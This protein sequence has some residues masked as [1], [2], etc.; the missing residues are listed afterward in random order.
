AN[1]SGDGW[2]LNRGFTVVTLGWQWDAYGDD[3]LRLFAPVAKQNSKTITGLLRGDY[4]PWKVMPDIPLGHFYARDAIGGS[5]Y[6]VA[7]RDDPR[8]VLTVRESREAPRTT[9][10]NSQWQ[11]A[12]TVDG[13]L[14]PGDRYIHLDG[15]FRPG[16][17]YEYIYVFADPAVAGLGFAAV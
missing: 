15:G 8:N 5:E 17:I 12:H 4:M 1:D 16:K 14:V 11:F 2:L 10:P 6:P 13:K 3:A 9:I 7:A